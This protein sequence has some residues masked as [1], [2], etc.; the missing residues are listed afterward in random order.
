MKTSLFTVVTLGAVLIAPFGPIA[1]GGHVAQAAQTGQY[2]PSPVDGKAMFDLYCTPCHGREGKGDGPA[3]VA[4]KTPPAD[5]TK[6][7]ARN[8]GTFPTDKIRRFIEG[9]EAVSGHGSREMPVWGSLF[10]GVDRESEMAKIR[11]A[12]LAD[13]LKSIQK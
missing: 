3:A 1:V 10:I 13:Y 9:R 2:T 4:L 5:L 6:I 7:S 11:I 12:N 8:K